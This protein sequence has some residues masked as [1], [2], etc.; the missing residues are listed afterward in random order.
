MTRHDPGEITE[1]LEALGTGRDGA[2]EELFE[3]VYGEL[4]R[5][6]HAQR[7]RWRGEETLNTTALIHEAYLKLAA[8]RLSGGR[9]PPEQDRARFFAV[10]ARAMRQI[11][12]D[13]ARRSRAERRGGGAAQVSL[14]DAGPA[15]GRTFPEEEL[16]ALDEALG[17]LE[18][19]DP[20]Q[21]RIVECRFF[22]GLDVEETAEAVGVSTATVKRDWRAARAWLH[23]E[24]TAG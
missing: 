14:T 22:A 4:R 7:R 20:R 6:A 17:R 21:V 18:E 19:I 3:A 1:L 12:I 5:L 15:A 2:F 8:G 9:L 10:A 11:L 16:L 13:R 23:R 24:L